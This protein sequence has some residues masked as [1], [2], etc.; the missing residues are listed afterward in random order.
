[1][2]TQTSAGASPVATENDPL[3]EIDDLMQKRRDDQQASAIRSA[4]L[5]AERSEFSTQFARVCQEQIRPAMDAIIERLRHNGGDAVI[6]EHHADLGRHH[7]HRLTMWMSLHG[8]IVGTPRQDR[9]PYLQLD[10]DVAKRNVTVSEGDVWEGHGGNRSG[11]I[12]QWLLSE[13][14]TSRVTEE[15]L[16]VLRR[17]FQ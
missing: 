7:D 11:K 1:M 4:Q 5:T 2:E 6:E 10:A 14:T 8:Q 17:A 3:S 16:A 13:I 12:G 15:I 9:H